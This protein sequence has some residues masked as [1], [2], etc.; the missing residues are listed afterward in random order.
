M[1]SSL[2]PKEI[3]MSGLM[4]KLVASLLFVIFGTLLFAGFQE[5]S[6]YGNRAPHFAHA[7]AQSG[8]L[9]NLEDSFK[10]CSELESWGNQVAVLYHQLYAKHTAANAASEDCSTDEARET[11][12]SLFSQ[13]AALF[14]DL[15]DEVELLGNSRL[16]GAT[17]PIHF[18]IEIRQTADMCAN[19]QTGVGYMIDMTYAYAEEDTSQGLA[20]GETGAEYCNQAMTVDDVLQ[21]IRDTIDTALCQEPSIELLSPEM[22]AMVDGSTVL[23]EWSVVDSASSYT[24]AIRRLSDPTYVDEVAQVRLLDEIPENFFD[25]EYEISIPGMAEVSLPAAEHEIELQPGATYAWQVLSFLDG[26]LVG[27]SNCGWCSCA[28]SGVEDISLHFSGHLAASQ[29][30]CR[31]IT[32]T[33]IS[34]QVS[35]GSPA[36]LELEAMVRKPSSAEPWSFGVTISAWDLPSWVSFEP[37]SG[38]GSVSTQAIINGP[39]PA[40][41][42]NDP[43]VTLLF[44]ATTADE[45]QAQLEVELVFSQPVPSGY[46]D[47]TLLS[48]DVP[49]GKETDQGIE[50][51]IPFMPDFSAFVL[52]G[53]TDCDTGDPIDAADISTEF[54]FS[55]TAQLPYQLTELETVIVSAPGYLPYEI[56]QFQPLTFNLLFIQITLL[57]PT[58]P[59]IC[60]LPTPSSTGDP[61]VETTSLVLELHEL[62]RTLYWETGT[63]TVFSDGEATATLE[64][65]EAGEK[66]VFV[67]VPAG[68]FV[69]LG[70]LQIDVA[71]TGDNAVSIAIAGPLTTVW[72]Y[73]NDPPCEVTLDSAVA[74]GLLVSGSPGDGLVVLPITIAVSGPCDVT[75]SELLVTFN[76]LCAM[77]IGFAAVIAEGDAEAF[78]TAW[79]FGDGS[80]DTSTKT[81]LG[82]GT[83]IGEVVHRY[84]MPGTYALCCTVSD[85]T[86]QK[87]TVIKTVKAEPTDTYV[88]VFGIRGGTVRYKLPGDTVWRRAKKGMRF[89]YGTQ[90]EAQ[91]SAKAYLR[92]IENGKRVGSMVVKPLSVCTLQKYVKKSVRSNLQLKIGTVRVR[93]DKT[94]LEASRRVSTPSMVAGVTGTSFESTYDK[95][96]GTSI[97][98]VFE[99]AVEVT[100]ERTGETVTITGD[101]AGTGQRA[102]VCGDT[103]LVET[104]TDMDAAPGGEWDFNAMFEEG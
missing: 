56:T 67:T 2:P 54:I 90:I 37:A 19:Y 23:F 62:E 79:D 44:T 12:R 14:E 43:T 86:G 64:Y 42:F 104:V 78:S 51:D 97:V 55:A 68:A 33:K 34:C 53:V 26:E 8:A 89:P 81:F 73:E 95:A 87:A 29:G 63:T 11:V 102:T 24:L 35:P 59:D 82:P 74:Y 7:F 30:T 100:N 10:L 9:V 91:V 4:R 25:V 58:V 72:L 103:I 18:G 47:L 28:I 52:G 88:E 80:R 22:G 38:V 98:L 39:G 60:L 83:V 96:T 48:Y 17:G 50:F 61:T 36:I 69:E 76:A 84:D 101:G 57:M 66:T 27:L 75:V 40:C 71:A 16:S 77:D 5:S 20:L 70:E 92:F 65:A 31:Q 6:P 1:L 49:E 3:E 46:G 21:A 99:G 93:V 13:A 15:L 41:G 32:D 85:E 45:L 94:A